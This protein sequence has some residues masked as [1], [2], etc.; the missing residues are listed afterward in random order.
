VGAQALFELPGYTA[1]SD[2]NTSRQW[3]LS[4]QAGVFF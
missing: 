2:L 4:L 3:T 1:D